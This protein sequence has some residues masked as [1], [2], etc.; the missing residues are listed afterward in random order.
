MSF[1][2]QS[3]EPAL[4]VGAS[5]IGI[6]SKSYEPGVKSGLLAPKY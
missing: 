6:S 2:Q 1:E 4:G 5:I 3:E